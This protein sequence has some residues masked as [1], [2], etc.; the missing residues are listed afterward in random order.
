MSYRLPQP[1]DPS[2]EEQEEKEEGDTRLD[3]SFLL[4]IDAGGGD[5][6]TPSSSMTPKHSAELT[7]ELTPELRKKLDGVLEGLHNLLIQLC[8][9]Y[10][11]GI[12]MVCYDM[13]MY[14][15]LAP[16]YFGHM[17]LYFFWAF[18]V[19]RPSL[20][21]LIVAWEPLREVTRC[22]R[23]SIVQMI[24]L[25]QFLFGSSGLSSRTNGDMVQVY[26][27]LCQLR[28]TLLRC[29]LC[30]SQPIDCDTSEILEDDSCCHR[31]LEE[32]SPSVVAIGTDKN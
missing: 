19:I 12:L 4:I 1:E 31:L 32:S 23:Q 26:E 22:L 7:D 24:L 27:D 29:L 18:H 2:L 10:F 5:L 11:L 17:F 25:P 20:K 3:G 6:L 8:L 13:I 9:S 16:I 15:L 14:D 21:S 30:Q 28:D